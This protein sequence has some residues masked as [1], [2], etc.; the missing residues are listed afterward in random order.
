MSSQITSLNVLS[1]HTKCCRGDGQSSSSSQEPPLS[2]SPEEE[3][4]V[5][6]E[7][8]EYDLRRRIS[9]RDPLAVMDAYHIHILL[10]LST[11]LGVRMC[12]FC[13]RC[14]DGIMGCS[15]YFGSNMRPVGGCCGGMEALGGAT[16]HQGNGTPHFHGEGHIVT[17]HQFD[18][19]AD[20]G[21]K[22]KTSKLT[23]EA[24]KRYQEWL[25]CEDI[26]DEKAYNT[27]LPR[28]EEE[29]ETRY[30]AREHD[31][32]STIPAYLQSPNAGA[33]PLTVSTM[34]TPADEESLL[35]DAHIFKMQYQEDSQFI[36]SR[37]QHHVHKR[38]KT[39]YVP[40]KACQRRVNKASCKCKHDFPKDNVRVRTSLI[41]C[42]GLA[43]RLKL[44][45][46]GRRNVLG[47]IIGRR[48]CAWQSGTSRAFAVV[49]RSN[50]HTLPNYRLPPLPETH[51][52]EYCKSRKCAECLDK[53]RLLKIVS[54][55]AQRAQRELTG[56]HCGYTFKGQPVGTRYLKGAA[57][58][59]SYLSTGFQ[60]KTPGQ[61]WHRTTH[62]F[63]TEMQNRC[64]SRTAP[65]E[66]N[67]CANWNGQDVTKAEFLRTFMSITF[68]GNL[69][70]RR[71]EAEKRRIEE[72]HIRCVLPPPAEDDDVYVKMF[73]DCYG[74]RGTDPRVYYLSPW[75]FLM[76]WEIIKTEKAGQHLC[77]S[78]N[79]QPKKRWQ[80]RS[81]VA[82]PD[83]TIVADDDEVI[84]YPLHCGEVHISIY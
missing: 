52:T 17:A 42:Q 49:F 69:L 57:E 19:L 73:D 7:L 24:C 76:R 72:R 50:T 6:V 1:L 59:L 15:D 80:T 26:I 18:S 68:P 58:S 71:L 38:T 65:E 54:K 36:F 64:M 84:E 33:G 62:R 75:E 66:T 61:Q 56:Y 35:K 44:R 39:G 37:V 41:M 21:L 23:P 83:A 47:T 22:V 5:S 43:R 45:V 27:F 63:L 16:E 2:A 29:W 10:R 53:P 3:D 55:L 77:A 79:V 34:M 81:Q 40:L 70:V 30:A 4:Q 11:V 48:R 8:P 82:N 32:M 9:A 60:D 20:I 14:N 51:E 25:H 12:P 78:P 31:A 13:P 28:V 67:L 46:S 74:F